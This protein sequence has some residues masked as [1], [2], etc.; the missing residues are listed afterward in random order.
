MTDP[1]TLS[2]GNTIGEWLAR[3]VGGELLRGLLIAAGVDEHRLAPVEGPPL[4]QLVGLSQGKIP[5]STIDDLI[6]RGSA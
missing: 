4:Q 2:A 6:R 5:Q 1:S 3:P